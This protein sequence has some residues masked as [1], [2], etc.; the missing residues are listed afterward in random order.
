MRTLILIVVT[1]ALA[2][3]VAAAAPPELATSNLNTPAGKMT[4]LAA[5]T[6]YQASSFPL[7]LRL[8]APD[9]TWAGSQWTTSAFGK[10]TFAW[11]AVGHGGTTPTTAPQGV[12]T[13]M[14]AIGPTPS[15]SATV[16]RL[17]RGGS[18]IT[19]QKTSPARVAGYRG[20]QFDGDVWGIFG[21]S[22]VP[23][24]PTTHGASP[25]DS[26]HIDKGEAFRFIVLGV[27]GRTVVLFEESFGLSP[28]RFP[29]F[30]TDAN[31]VLASLK[32]TAV[33]PTK[34]GKS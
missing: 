13:I 30:L 29:A 9:G 14:T 26:W 20:T 4:A 5:K 22:F 34:A 28:D 24:T 32:F 10:K 16:A 21:H 18:G 23:F 25:S 12:V 19:F 15:V 2:A 33:Q 27:K 3:G 1:L 7:G 11:V 6:V 31:R 8:T 17:R